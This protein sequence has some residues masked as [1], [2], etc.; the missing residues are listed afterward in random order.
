[1]HGRVLH[2]HVLQCQRSRKQAGMGVKGRSHEFGESRDL[3]LKSKPLLGQGG[4]CI[5]LLSPGRGEIII[6]GVC[7]T[8]QRG[9]SYL[10]FEVRQV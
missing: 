2:R 5:I 1:M 9:L 4:F 7:D 6:L 10:T 3:I 8:A